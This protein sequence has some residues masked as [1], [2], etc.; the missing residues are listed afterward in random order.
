MDS[1]HSKIQRQSKGLPV[2][3]SEKI[4]LVCTR[5]DRRI[6]LRGVVVNF[7]KKEGLNDHSFRHTHATQLIE[8]GAF[9]GK[10]SIISFNY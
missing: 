7:L 5:N 3:V 6:I 4:S 9:I 10:F 2:S 8:S 1:R